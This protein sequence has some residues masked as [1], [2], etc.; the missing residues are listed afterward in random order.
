MLSI[1]LLGI[2]IGGMT[3]V[4]AL[5]NTAPV[6]VSFFSDQFTAP[7]AAVIVLSLLSGITITLLAMLPR[8]IRD[9][10]D[11][12]ARRREQKTM[13]TEQYASASAPAEQKIVA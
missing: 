4:F 13:V 11:A 8:F 3:V 12:Y 1:L 6:T 7:L 9:A 10:L 2:F 5:E